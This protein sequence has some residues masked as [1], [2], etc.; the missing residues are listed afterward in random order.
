M[1]NP[2][3]KYMTFVMDRGKLGQH[4]SEEKVIPRRC[5]HAE[6]SD[7]RKNAVRKLKSQI[8]QIDITLFNEEKT[9]HFLHRNVQFLEFFNNYYS[10][11]RLIAIFMS[12]F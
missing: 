7:D 3:Q 12:F 10:M 1:S 11:L 2:A 5:A 4:F 9:L 8:L 6:R